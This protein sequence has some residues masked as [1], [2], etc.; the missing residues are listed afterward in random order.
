MKKKIIKAILEKKTLKAAD[1]GLDLKQFKD[2]LAAMR[3]DGYIDG[4]VAP[5]GNLEP[6]LNFA[7]VTP[8]GRKIIEE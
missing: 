1:V 8:E 7:T 4:C 2:L 3:E 5:Q 6:M